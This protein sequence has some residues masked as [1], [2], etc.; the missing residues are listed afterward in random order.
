MKIIRLFYIDIHESDLR[1][2]LYVP[3]IYI[4]TNCE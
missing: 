4:Y 3:N 2:I 1:M